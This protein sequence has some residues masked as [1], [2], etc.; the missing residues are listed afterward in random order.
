MPLTCPECERSSTECIC[1]LLNSFK[2]TGMSYGKND[3]VYSHKGMT[4]V[5]VANPIDRQWRQLRDL[6]NKEVTVRIALVEFNNRISARAKI[7]E[8]ET[9][10]MMSL[11]G[12]HPNTL[13]CIG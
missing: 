6:A 13:K 4:P 5:E 7:I 11:G 1:S 8:E 2:A 12:L 9:V 3:K 10:A